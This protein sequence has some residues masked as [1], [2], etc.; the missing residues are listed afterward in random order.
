M[1]ADSVWRAVSDP[2]RRRLIELLR[3]G[4]RT[5]GDLS[6]AFSTTRFAVMKHLAVLERC[7]VVRV[8]R[9][10][11]ERWN[12]LEPERLGGLDARWQAAPAGESAAREA[13]GAAATPPGEPRRQTGA[14][15]E[16]PG[17]VE[18]RGFSH[19]LQVFIDAPPWRVF[20]ALTVNVASWWGA[21]HLLA[22][23]ATNL[24]LEPQP[25]GRFYEEWGHRQGALRGLVA[26]IK[27]DERL[28]LTGAVF[29]AG[30]SVLGFVLERREGGTLV[31]ASHTSAGATSG[32]RT[33]AI[34]VLEDLVRARLKPFVEQGTR[35]G[36][37]S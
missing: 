8:R 26:A 14:P 5:T 7:G 20:D 11:R 37:L 18:P 9:S 13:P 29:G 4:P 16:Q 27:Q 12:I 31:T 17:V 3:D 32:S 15:A 25:G 23:D 28:E 22:A 1:S 24:V 6:R 35:S 36:V 34:A 30:D 10:G 19:V 21:P 2:T 33:R